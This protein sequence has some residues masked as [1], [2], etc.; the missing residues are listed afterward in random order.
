MTKRQT[1][2]QD[3]RIN[4]LYMQRCSGV[5]IDIFD[6]SKVF[7]S[8][9]AFIAANNPTDQQLGDHIHAFVQTIRRN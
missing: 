5:Q 3:A 6:I 4:H 1:K 8:A 7:R 2:T 9:A